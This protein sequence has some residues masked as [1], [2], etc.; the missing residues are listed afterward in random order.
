LFNFLSDSLSLS[1]PS[2]LRQLDS[3]SLTRVC[4][5]LALTL[6][7]KGAEEWSGMFQFHR[8]LSSFSFFSS[9]PT[10]P[11]ACL[12]TLA[13]SHSSLFTSFACI[14]ARPILKAVSQTIFRLM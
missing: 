8:T 6:V 10:V 5:W 1:S 2:C 3:S 9:S 13:Q 7:I 12:P 4:V 11:A 14:L